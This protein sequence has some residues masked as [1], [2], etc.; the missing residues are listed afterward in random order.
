MVFLFSLALVMQISI[1]DYFF[2]KRPIHKLLDNI[3]MC[4][5]S[6][7][8][9]EKQRRSQIYPLFQSIIEDP[10]TGKALPSELFL[11]NKI[12]SLLFMGEEF[13]TAFLDSFGCKT[14]Q[15]ND[16][17]FS[18]CSKDGK[19]F[20][21][22]NESSRMT[23]GNNNIKTVHD[24]PLMQCNLPLSHSAK[25]ICS[26]LPQVSSHQCD[27][28]STQSCG[29]S[30]K[31]ANETVNI[32][33]SKLKTQGGAQVPAMGSQKKV[34]Q[35]CHL[36]ILEQKILNPKNQDTILNVTSGVLH[37]VELAPYPSLY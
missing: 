34:N 35:S 12:I 27:Q 19:K 25:A 28:S 17:N 24:V 30:V 10:L 5:D 31:C 32:W 23:T 36:R 18:A 1:L 20:F 3:A 6:A 16:V 37:F 7:S 2:S 14:E 11:E 26:E 29:D 33:N 22:T 21:A 15:A 9:I 4:F 8:D 13:K